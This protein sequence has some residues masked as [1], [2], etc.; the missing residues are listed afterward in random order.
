MPPDWIHIPF[1][2]FIDEFKLFILVDHHQVFENNHFKVL[3]GSIFNSSSDFFK[4]EIFEAYIYHESFECV[5]LF[6]LISEPLLCESIEIEF[7]ISF[8]FFYKIIH[9]L[10]FIMIK[11]KQFN[12]DL[13]GIVSIFIQAH[14]FFYSFCFKNL[15]RISSDIRV[16]HRK[17]LW[18]VLGQKLFNKVH[19]EVLLVSQF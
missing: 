2:R 4:Y 6:C 16:D 9:E 12:F 10:F 7:I 15:M 17:I 18:F 8:D 19:R 1:V 13:S 5:F 11:I 3:L 14:C